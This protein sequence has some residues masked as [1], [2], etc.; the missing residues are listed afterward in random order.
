MCIFTTIYCSLRYDSFDDNELFFVIM[1]VILLSIQIIGIYSLIPTITKPH[2][3][4]KSFNFRNKYSGLFEGMR[5]YDLTSRKLAFA[6]V[7][8]RILFISLIVLLYDDPSYQ[9]GV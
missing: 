8:R 1:A 3:Q 7:F 5:V 2:Y 4:L 6:L 9:V